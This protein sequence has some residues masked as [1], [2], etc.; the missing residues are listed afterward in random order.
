M[1]R[2]VYLFAAI[3]LVGFMAP[4]KKVVFF[5][6]GDST[7]ADKP[8]ANNPERGW[9]QLFPQYISNAVEIK[10]LAVN[11]RST[12]SFIKEGRWDTV[13]KY[14]KEGDYVF[15]QFGHNDSKLDGILT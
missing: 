4:E 15:I 6:I 11:G 13:M 7:M 9:G 8:L 14:M 12:K 5:M 10:N 1:K 2:I 3:I